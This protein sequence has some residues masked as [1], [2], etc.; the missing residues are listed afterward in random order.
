M[1]FTLV[2]MTRPCRRYNCRGLA[3]S[4]LTF[5]Y[6]TAQ[7]WLE[8]L[9]HEAEPQRWDLCGDHAGLLTV[10]VGWRLIDARSE[11]EGTG[12]PAAAGERRNRYAE[13]SARLPALAAE[14]AASSPLLGLRPTPSGGTDDGAPG[15]ASAQGEPDD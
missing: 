12:G 13:L 7:A 2:R 11:A 6:D 1:W 8:D 9:A 5:R 10:P 14:V 15:G 3:T 4:T